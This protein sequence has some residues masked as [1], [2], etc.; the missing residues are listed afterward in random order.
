MPREIISNMHS[1]LYECE[2][3]LLREE[4]SEFEKIKLLQ[5]LSKE[6]IQ[7]EGMLEPMVSYAENNILNWVEKMGHKFKQIKKD[8]P[9]L[10]ANLIFTV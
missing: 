9:H 8:S 6:N 5:K 2:Q 4:R 7:N 1:K 10:M 3:V